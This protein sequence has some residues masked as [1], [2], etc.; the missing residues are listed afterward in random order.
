MWTK[1][2][3]EMLDDAKV[4]YYIKKIPIREQRQQDGHA[5][6]E[7]FFASQVDSLRARSACEKGLVLQRLTNNEVQLPR[8]VVR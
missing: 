2:L 1:A 6:L 5:R 3:L 8:F 7:I 4:V